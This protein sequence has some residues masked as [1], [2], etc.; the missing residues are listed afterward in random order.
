VFDGRIW[1]LGGT[2]RNDAW[3]SIDGKEW[4]R[5]F[6]ASPWSKRNTEYSVAFNDKLWLFS[7]KTG[8]E[9]SWDGAIWAM[10]RESE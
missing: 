9:D 5:E 8:R 3:S 7:G 10:S 2:N 1:V 6:S 4:M